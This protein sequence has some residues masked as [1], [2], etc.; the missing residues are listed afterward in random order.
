MNET[1]LNSFDSTSNS[2]IS[3]AK[4]Y[5]GGLGAESATNESIMKA[6]Q[7]TGVQLYNYERKIEN[8]SCTNFFYVAD[9]KTGEGYDMYT[10]TE[11]YYY[12]TNPTSWTGKLA[13]MYVSD[14][15]YASENCENKMMDEVTDTGD[16][17]ATPTKDIEYVMIQIGYT[18]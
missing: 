17:A 18:I 5:L 1:Y 9:E 16:L 2:L 6:A 14:Y 8:G 7:T 10:G 12:G 13:L 11:C 3:N 4:Y 15:F